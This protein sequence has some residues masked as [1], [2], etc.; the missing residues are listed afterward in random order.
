M[1]SNQEERHVLDGLHLAA[2]LEVGKPRSSAQRNILPCSL[3]SAARRSQVLTSPTVISAY[4]CN[5]SVASC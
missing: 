5:S 2:L 4:R 3:A 1:E